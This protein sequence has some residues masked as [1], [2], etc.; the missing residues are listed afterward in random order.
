MAWELLRANYLLMPLL[1]AQCI[2]ISVKLILAYPPYCPPLT[3]IHK[4]PERPL[5]PGECLIPFALTCLSLSP[6]A[7]AW[8][9]GVWS[10]WRAS[11]ASLFPFIFVFGPH[12]VML[13][14]NY[15]QAYGTTWGAR[16]QVVYVQSKHLTCCIIS[17]IPFIFIIIS[18]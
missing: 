10:N 16:D 1:V 17:L 6:V 9:A 8:R 7:E 2:P 3:F 13:R 5:V 14:D 11:W 18:Y 12:P 4:A 15:W